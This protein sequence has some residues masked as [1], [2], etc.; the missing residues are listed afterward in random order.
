MNRV[1]TMPR[2]RNARLSSSAMARPSARE[3]ATMDTVMTTV[4][5]TAERNSP[6]VNTRA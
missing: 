3:T 1:R 5:P 4:V 6:S 2:P